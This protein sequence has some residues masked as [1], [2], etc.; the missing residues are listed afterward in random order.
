LRWGFFI[1]KE[2][3]NLPAAA[4]CCRL[5]GT[6]GSDFKYKGKTKEMI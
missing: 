4:G 6:N 5:T 1:L 3:Y 2:I